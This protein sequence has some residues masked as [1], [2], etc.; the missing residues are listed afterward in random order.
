RGAGVHA[1][2]AID[3]ALWDLRGKIEGVPVYRLLGEAKQ[4]RVTPYASLQPAGDSFE[5]Y[6]DSLVEWALRAKEMGFRA[7]KT[8][9]T[10]NGPY[11]HSGLREPYERH[12]E[13][14]AAVRRAI[15]PDIALL[16]DVQYMFDDVDVAAAVLDEWAEFDL[17]FIETPLWVDDLDGHAR[18]A[19]RIPM[20]VASGEWLATRYEFEE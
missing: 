14:V 10:M 15:G 3:A 4:Q 12:T 11:A 17:S 19:E 6:R 7:V 18:L 5:Q 1:I 8:E 2:G 9:V 13:V 16:V 20:R